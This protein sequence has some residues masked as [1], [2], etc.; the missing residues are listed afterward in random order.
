[1]NRDRMHRSRRSMPDPGIVMST[2]HSSR[3]WRLTYAIMSS[4]LASLETGFSPPLGNLYRGINIYC[5]SQWNYC[6]WFHRGRVFLDTFFILGDA[7]SRYF[8]FVIQIYSQL[9]SCTISMYLT[10]PFISLILCRDFHCK[11]FRRHA[12]LS[13]V[14]AG[15]LK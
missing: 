13:G 8:F 14:V 6:R 9:L 5:A 7:T 15:E 12:D 10:V 11:F 2:S 4:I 3:L 1:M